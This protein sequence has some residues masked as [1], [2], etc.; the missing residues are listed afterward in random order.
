[1]ADDVDAA[2]RMRDVAGVRDVADHELDAGIDGGQAA[3]HVAA[4]RVE[5]PHLPAAG[6]GGVDDGAAD[7][8][9][10]AGD[11]EVAA[12]RRPPGAL[13]LWVTTGSFG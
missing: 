13:V 6:E 4:E 10:A 1:M 9:G 7:E 12:G 11:E 5:H 3:V 8:S 2:Q